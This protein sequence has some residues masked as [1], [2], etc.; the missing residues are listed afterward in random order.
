MEEEEEK[1]EKEENKEEKEKERSG[2][3][4]ER[5]GGEGRG[6]GRGGGRRNIRRKRERRRERRRK[7]VREEEE[8]QEEE[9]EK[10]ERK[11]R[12]RRKE[13]KKLLQESGLGFHKELILR[14][15]FKGEKLAFCT[16][17]QPLLAPV[18]PHNP[19]PAK[20]FENPFSSS[21]NSISHF[22]IQLSD[23]LFIVKLKEKKMD[24]WSPRC[25]CHLC[26]SAF[27]FP[28]FCWLFNLSNRP[29]QAQV[30]EGYSRPLPGLQILFRAMDSRT[31]LLATDGFPPL[32]DIPN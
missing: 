26:I 3:R 7:R 9:G 31:S 21:V 25:Y 20:V 12:G 24:I 30:R 6:E 10:E 1:E 15:V 22:H 14:E 4:E 5:E 8:E 19:L 32:L 13:R 28:R 18:P 29:L 17:L 2:G 27:R 16:H 11:G 23:F